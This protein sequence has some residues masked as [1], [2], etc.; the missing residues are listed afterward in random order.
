MPKLTLIRGLPGSGKSTLAE[1]LAQQTFAVH[2]EADHF[3]TQDDGS[4]RYNARRIKDAHIWCQGQCEYYLSLDFDVIVANTFVELWE[5]Q[6]YHQL[7][8]KYQAEIEVIH[9]KGTWQNIHNVSQASI[10]DMK[11]RWQE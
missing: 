5:M 8:D 6:I 11:K 7:A 4:Y 2:L 10:D 9:C 1:K 3:F